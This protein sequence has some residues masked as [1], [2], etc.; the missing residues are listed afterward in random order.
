[1]GAFFT[2][3]EEFS[4]N[5]LVVI[6]RSSLPLPGRTHGKLWNT[7]GKLGILSHSGPDKQVGFGDAE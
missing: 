7:G 6:A 4:S 5:V 3:G 2:S 1:M